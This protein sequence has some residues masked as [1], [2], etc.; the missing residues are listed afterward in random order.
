[1]RNPNKVVELRCKLAG[2]KKTGKVHR[3]PYWEVPRISFA[4]KKKKPTRFKVAI[5]EVSDGTL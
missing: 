3:E 5:E 4:K 1:M 2:Q